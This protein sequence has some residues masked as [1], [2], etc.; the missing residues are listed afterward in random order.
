MRLVVRPIVAAALVAML[1]ATALGQE[2]KARA[3]AQTRYF[4]AQKCQF[5]LPAGRWSWTDQPLPDTFFAAESAAGL[6]VRASCAPA[7]A[8]RQMNES[9]A[10]D[11]ESSLVQGSGGQLKKRGAVYVQFH[12]LSCYQVAGVYADGRTT[13]S[14][15]F[16]AH[17]LAYHILVVGGKEPVEQ[18]PD[19]D[20]IMDG[21][22]FTEPPLAPADAKQ[23]HSTEYYFGYAFFW[24]FLLFVWRCFR[25]KPARR[26]RVARYLDPDDDFEDLAPSPAPI[27]PTFHAENRGL[28]TAQFMDAARPIPRSPFAEGAD[29]RTTEPLDVEPASQAE[30]GNRYK[31]AGECR[32]CGY[33]PVAFSAE[34][35]PRCGGSNPNPGVVSK[36]T[37]RGA[38]GG[39]LMGI[40]VGGSWG[41][42]SFGRGGGG[43]AIAGALLGGL[44]G[45]IL[46]L[47]AGL[48]T[49]ITARVLGKR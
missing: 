49:G 10:K 47:A 41:Y 7:A 16:L 48:V 25:G 6:V 29:P 20:K 44:A 24:I 15:C 11:F 13:A 12:G 19:F 34:E 32:H 22:A 36:F 37:G 43:G 28:R 3:A 42:L 40:L 38:F 33:R 2:P 30:S 14:R 27:K 18:D 35:C 5:T 31:A 1:G 26:K 21:F 39:A 45:I 8:W 23:G 46:G 17:G 9:A 4:S